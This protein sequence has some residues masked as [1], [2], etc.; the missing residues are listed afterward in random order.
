MAAAILGC[1]LALLDSFRQ[2]GML[3]IMSDNRLEVQGRAG[4]SGSSVTED[5]W[6]R[7]LLLK[8]KSAAIKS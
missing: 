7:S 1:E 4:S 3:P 5:E 8:A 6:R 2:P